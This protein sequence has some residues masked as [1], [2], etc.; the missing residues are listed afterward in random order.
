MNRPEQPPRGYA[1]RECPPF[2]I[3]RSENGAA[4]VDDRVA[5]EAEGLWP[6]C[7]S[8][9]ITRLHDPAIAAQIL[10]EVAAK[11]SARLWQE[12]RVGEKLRPYLF[13]SYVRRLNAMVRKDTRLQYRGLARDL[14]AMLA[15]V[16]PQWA[17]EVEVRLVFEA[18]SLALDQ[19]G[20]RMLNLRRVGYSWRFIGDQFGLTAKQARTAFSYRLREA[21]RDFFGPAGS[22][23]D[24][25]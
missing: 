13:R 25:E 19:T 2:W 22:A 14:E 8:L 15:P 7:Y 4:R 1:E 3:A 17:R 11:V 18:I 21:G 5:A 20:R 12:D 23:E 24:S 10:E 6:W 9:A 16:S